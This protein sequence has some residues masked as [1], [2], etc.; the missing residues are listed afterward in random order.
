MNG[1]KNRKL[2]AQCGAAFQR[3]NH[4]NASNRVDRLHS[5]GPLKFNLA[6]HFGWNLIGALPHRTPIRRIQKKRFKQEQRAFRTLQCGRMGFSFWSFWPFFKFINIVDYYN[7]TCLAWKCVCSK[8]Q[9]SILIFEIGT[10]N[11]KTSLLKI[12][13]FLIYIWMINQRIMN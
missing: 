10:V 13:V 1:K 2:V 6:K 12:V 5:F 4:P 3:R 11:D 7:Y 8:V 9:N